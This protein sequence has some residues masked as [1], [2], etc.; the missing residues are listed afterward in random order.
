LGTDYRSDAKA[1]SIPDTALSRENQLY[2]LPMSPNGQEE[3]TDFAFQYSVVTDE[4]HIPICL[5]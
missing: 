3:Y 4:I 1:V 5:K 2:D